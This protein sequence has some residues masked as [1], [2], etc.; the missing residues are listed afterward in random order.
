[1]KNIL[2]NGYFGMNFGDD[3]F[4]K[5]LFDRYPNVKFNFYNNYYL[6][7]YYEFY[8][9]I[10]KG[11]DNV[12]VKKYNGIRRY[13]DKVNML[14]AA[15]NIQFS[16]YDA[17]IFIGGSIFMEKTN[18]GRNAREKQSIYDYFFKKDKPVYILG[19]N[20]GPYNS[21][22]FK[23]G[24]EKVFSKCKDVCFREEHSYSLFNEINTVR[25]AP[26]IVFSLKHKKINKIKDSI[27]ISLID[28]RDRDGLSEISHKFEEKI[29]LLTKKFI[30]K[31]KNI[32]FFSFSE[33]EGDL[34]AIN[35]IIKKLDCK[36]KQKIKVCNY[37]GD[38]NEFLGEFAS[39]E[40][41]I[42][43]RFHSVILS[44]VF[45]QGVYP[46]IYSDKT[47]NV[48]ND[49]KLDRYYKYIKDINSLDINEVIQQIDNNKIKD[50]SIFNNAEKQFEKLD[51]FL[52]G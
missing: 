25:V 35:N 17:N 9:T 28:I 4:F 7:S 38:I 13:L 52:V 3:L 46:L 40:N 10:F 5:I 51:E 23:E 41:I 16:K 21:Q 45:D 6:K 8:K 49:I 36:Y 29:E 12:T 19:C 32:T 18:K 44:Q 33:E 20:F 30:D 2:V 37:S 42:G 39:Q 48:I 50:K 15:N 27:G 1:M 34:V 47:Y 14:Q 43:C 11:Y 31:G 22:E 26:D 24:Y